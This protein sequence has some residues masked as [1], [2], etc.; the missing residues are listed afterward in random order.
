MTNFRENKNLH[1][2]FQFMGLQTLGSIFLGGF[3]NVEWVRD[4]SCEMLW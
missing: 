4:L 3:V 2:E 1:H